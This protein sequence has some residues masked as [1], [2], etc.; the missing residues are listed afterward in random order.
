MA[1]RASAPLECASCGWKTKRRLE[2]ANKG[3]SK[4]GGHL[5]WDSSGE[6]NDPALVVIA[7]IAVLAMLLFAI[8]WEVNGLSAY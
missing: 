8:V 7:V 6:G 4:C 3:C 1:P 5:A 2:D